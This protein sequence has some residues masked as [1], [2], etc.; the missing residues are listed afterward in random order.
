MPA[1]VSSDTPAPTDETV[2]PSATTSGKLSRSHAAAYLTRIDLPTTL[3]DAPPS[4]DLLRQLQSSHI[5][6]V[7]FESLTVHVPNWHDHSAPIFLGGGETVT[8]GEEAYRRIVALKRGGYCFSL[9]S[10]FAALLRS[11]GFRV[12]E[13]A[14]RVFSNQMKDPEEAGY[15]WE[16][17]SHQVS[18]VDWEG[19]DGRY[20]ADV[21]FG[22][23]SAFPI[24]LVSG[25]Q[26]LSQPDSTLYRIEQSLRLPGI[27]PSLLPDSAPYWTVWR[28]CVSP[29]EKGNKPY[30][31]PVYAF[32]LQSVPFRDFVTYNH[33]QS[34]HPAAR[35]RT[36]FCATVLHPNG[37]RSTLQY[38]E[39]QGD[40]EGE[41]KAKLTRTAPAKAECGENEGLVRDEQRECRW[42]E[43]T[44]GAVREVLE[45]EFGML[46]PEDYAGN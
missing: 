31:S 26:V 9:N 22:R 6:T 17:T 34:T 3:L 19:S 16:S 35:F 32:L 7:P 38:S 43:M 14:A 30:F 25:E 46:F 12:S 41:K 39:G 4:L 8:L 44:V 28:Q 10:T 20:L 13:C 1:A 5:F 36:F 21:G 18:I 29:P 37:E 23:S 2:W 11:F 45:K 27:S 40:D 24:P 15:E 42:I 33:Y